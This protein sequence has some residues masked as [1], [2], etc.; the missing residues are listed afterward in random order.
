MKKA[1]AFLL[2]IIGFVLVFFASGYISYNKFLKTDDE[3]A[4]VPSDEVYHEENQIQINEGIVVAGDTN[5]T[6]ITPG[7][8]DSD[9]IVRYGTIEDLNIPTTSY[10]DEEDIL[11]QYFEVEEVDLTVENVKAE[12]KTETKA[13][14]K[15]ETK[16][17]TKAE[18]KMET[19]T[20]VKTETKPQTQTEVKAEEPVTNQETA[21]QQP[22]AEEPVQ[23]ENIDKQPV[24]EVVEEVQQVPLNPNIQTS[25]SGL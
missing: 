7:L 4:I 6:I 12:A 23:T 8:N 3:N 20:E 18:S 24:E 25:D 21:V 5:L 15:T 16:T 9:T 14:T 11:D 13:E 1:G 19:K 2:F 22:V 17:E 10:A